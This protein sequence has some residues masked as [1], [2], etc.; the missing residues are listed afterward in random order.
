MTNR[1][2]REVQCGHERVVARELPDK[3]GCARYK[4]G[5]PDALIQAVRLRVVLCWRLT[6]VAT[7]FALNRGRRR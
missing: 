2:N 5:E 1:R 4:D 3:D 6:I 7:S